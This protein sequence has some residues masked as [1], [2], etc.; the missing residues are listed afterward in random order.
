M[1]LCFMWLDRAGKSLEVL[2]EPD[3]VPGLPAIAGW[4]ALHSGATG[5]PLATLI[6]G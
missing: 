4:Q 1:A 3:I 6:C 5:G 2:S